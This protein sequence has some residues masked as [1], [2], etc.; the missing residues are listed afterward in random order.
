V[1]LA[2]GNAASLVTRY[3]NVKQVLSD[4]RFTRPL[5]RGEGARVG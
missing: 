4:S 5:P 3:D 1:T 2:S